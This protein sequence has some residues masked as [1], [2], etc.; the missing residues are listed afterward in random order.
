ML[1]FM[2][3]VDFRYTKLYFL[4]AGIGILSFPQVLIRNSSNTKR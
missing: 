4:D 1:K 3:R 2:F